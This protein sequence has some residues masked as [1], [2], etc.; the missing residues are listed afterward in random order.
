M[1]ALV[2]H[3]AHPSAVRYFQRLE[4]TQDMRPSQKVVGNP[5]VL[6]VQLVAQR[7]RAYDVVRQAASLLSLI[8]SDDMQS[9]IYQTFLR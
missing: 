1:E 2:E 6:I 7:L 3:Y 4:G 5:D 9:A 8:H